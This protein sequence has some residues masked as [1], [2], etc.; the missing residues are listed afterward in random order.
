MRYSYSNLLTADIAADSLVCFV[1]QFDKL[2][3]RFLKKIDQATD[4]MVTALLKS[5]EFSG[6]E[7]ESALFYDVDGFQS[8]RTILLGLGERLIRFLPHSLERDNAPDYPLHLVH[9]FVV[10]FLTIFAFMDIPRSA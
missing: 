10:P 7:G 1:T 2:N 4:G 3:T 8:R 6:K 9:Y 5:A